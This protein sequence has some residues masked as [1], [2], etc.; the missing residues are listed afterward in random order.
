MLA[1]GI[2][3]LNGWYMAA[4]DGANKRQAEWPPHPDR[5]FMA[6]A[7]AWFETGEDKD[8][9][10]ALRWLEALP[11]PAIT[12]SEATFRTVTTSFVPVNDDG[13][14]KK[15]SPKND[16][17]RLRNR[18][19]AVVP[20]HRLRQPRGFPI[21]I[22]R[23]PFVYLTWREA[24]L[25]GHWNALERLASK[26]THVGHSASFVQAWVEKDSEVAAVWEPTEGIAI[27]RLRVPY[28][29]RLDQL[30]RDGNRSAWIAFSD[31]KGKIK[32]AREQL[33]A[34]GLPPRSAWRGFPDAVLLANES[35][36]KQHA[37]YSAAKAGSVASAKK[38]VDTLVS[39]S[40]VER[41]RLLIS[42]ASQGGEAPTLVCAHAYE[43]ESV[44]AIPIA[45]AKLLGERLGAPFEE[46]VV[47]KK[48]R[49]PYG[50]RRLRT[51]CSPSLF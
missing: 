48:Y 33:K 21:A 28:P 4:L 31:L 23:N 29:T 12:A 15:S 16:L 37:E 36:T 7:A 13:G 18:G 20:K 45:L 49:V 46:A 26:I 39:D 2:R 43:R 34:M 32:S 22:P 38:L 25:N 30:I 35:S 47:Q 42:T 40:G 24:D 6:M 51:S 19:L 41:V 44:N 3:Y 9:G 1:I 11:P 10:E 5:V 27:H 8:E 50:C 17:E 14:G